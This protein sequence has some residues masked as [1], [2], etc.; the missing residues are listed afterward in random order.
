M[1]YVI[2]VVSHAKHNRSARAALP[3]NPS[4]RQYLGENQIRVVRGR[5]RVVTEDFVKKYLSQLMAKQEAHEIEV[6]T[7]DGRKVDL[8]TL[9]P[10]P[11][12]AVTPL[13]HPPLDSVA[14]DKRFPTPVGY[15]YIP[16]YVND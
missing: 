8:L 11:V 13:P 15:K 5:P 9:T 10:E 16:P 12:P 4:K 6:R 7:P 3:K 2:H 1:D 14:N